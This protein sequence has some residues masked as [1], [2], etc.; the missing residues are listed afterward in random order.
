M[1][2]NSRHE[3]Y[4]NATARGRAAPAKVDHSNALVLGKCVT[5]EYLSRNGQREE[6]EGDLLAG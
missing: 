2:G 5:P 6:S 4:D 3:Y 1:I